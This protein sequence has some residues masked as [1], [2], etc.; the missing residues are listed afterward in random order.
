MEIFAFI[1]STLAT[2]CTCIPSF[3]KGKNMKLILL[4]VFS[5]NTLLATSYILT[6]AF[7]GAATCGIGAIQTIINYFFER[8]NKP[9]PVPL[10]A[11]Y[12]AAFIF[13]NLLVFTHITDIIAILAAMAFICSISQKSGKQ[14]RLWALVNTALWVVYDVITLSFG[15]LSTH[16]IL[17]VTTLAGMA[18]HDRKKT[19]QKAE[20]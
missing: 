12:A 5:T 10:I 9:I 7:N 15:P 6:G 14:Y 13:V 2:I 19:N 16:V 11:I 17:L 4:L 20:A 1:L 8:K 18:I 3:L